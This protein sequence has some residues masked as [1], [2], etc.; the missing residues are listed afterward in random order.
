MNEFDA[1]EPIDLKEYR[2]QYRLLSDKKTVVFSLI[3][4]IDEETGEKYS[5]DFEIK[6]FLSL[7][8]RGVAAA[9]FSRRNIGINSHEEVYTLNKIICELQAKTV[10]C[11]DWFKDEKAFEIVGLQPIDRIYTLVKAAQEE[12]RDNMNSR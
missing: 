9:N 5:G 2:S 11:P 8:E 3:N 12:Y 1:L 10:V 6:L 7:K 4:I